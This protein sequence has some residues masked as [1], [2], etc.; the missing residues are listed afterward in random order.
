MACPLSVPEK[1]G[2]CNSPEAGKEEERGPV[3][4]YK[5]D[6]AVS[7]RDD[8]NDLSSLRE[9]WK[10][11]QEI[12]DGP[13]NEVTTAKTADKMLIICFERTEFQK[14]YLIIDKFRTQLQGRIFKITKLGVT[15]R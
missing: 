5:I 3:K 11:V 8:S 12:K 4:G 9:D 6:G 14:Y 10:E 2:I 13:L 1:S 7:A 15:L